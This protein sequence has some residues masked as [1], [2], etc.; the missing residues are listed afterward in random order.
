[1]I[2]TFGD[3]ALAAI[4]HIRTGVTVP[5]LGAVENPR[6]ASFVTVQ[7]TGGPRGDLI[8]DAAQLT[9]ECWAGTIE[10]AHDLAQ[11]ARAL[12]HDLPGRTVAG[13]TV[14]RVDEFGGPAFLPDPDSATP[15]FTFTATVAARCID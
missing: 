15:R 3:A 5:V 6:P 2:V 12:L 10:A 4:T 9:V 11:Q 1:M 13:V 14:Y 7:R 8:T